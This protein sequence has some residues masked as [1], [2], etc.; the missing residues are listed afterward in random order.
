MSSQS[1]IFISSAWEALKAELIDKVVYDDV[2]VFTAIRKDE[3]DKRLLDRCYLQF[4]ADRRVQEAIKGLRELERL[5]SMYSS[6]DNQIGRDKDMYPYLVRSTW[7]Q[8]SV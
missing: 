1:A 8:S 7:L 6:D 4:L 2:R 3:M 5:S